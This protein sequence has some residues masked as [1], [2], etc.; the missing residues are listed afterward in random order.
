[1]SDQVRITREFL[2]KHDACIKSIIFLE[3]AGLSGIP[4]SMIS[5]IE[6]DYLEYIRW[7]LDREFDDKG[8][9]LYE[10]GGHY[11]YDDEGKLI[12]MYADYVIPLAEEEFVYTGST[13]TPTAEFI[14][15]D[16]GL[17]QY[18]E[19]TSWDCS[20]MRTVF[21][22]NE[23][24]KLI[25]ES[26]PTGVDEYTEY[27]SGGRVSKFSRTFSNSTYTYT[28]EYMDDGS[29]IT[30]LTDPDGGSYNEW[31]IYDRSGNVIY[32]WS[33]ARGRGKTY[34]T[35]NEYGQCVTTRT[36]DSVGDQ[37]KVYTYDVFGN[38]THVTTTS[39]AVHTECIPIIDYIELYADGQ[40]K[41]MKHSEGEIHIPWFE[42]G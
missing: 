22:Y 21:E 2:E 32:N 20:K 24:G 9:L 33:S 8:N 26:D 40:L 19:H 7:L 12:K 18:I 37:L 17:L 28:Y 38:L 15:D 29:Y 4:L 11:E 25:R 34:H 35:Y 13:M 14:Y 23:A 10:D 30:H 16:R 36:V 39:G 27:D 3:R 31:T 5:E 42:K 1:M 6:G 41:Y